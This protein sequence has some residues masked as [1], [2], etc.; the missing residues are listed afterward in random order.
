MDN[1]YEAGSGAGFVGFPEGDREFRKSAG[2]GGSP[3]GIEMDK[4][5]GTGAEDRSESGHGG[6]I[7]VEFVRGRVT[8]VGREDGGVGAEELD[9]GVGS[10]LDSRFV[11]DVALLPGSCTEADWTG[12][13]DHPG[14]GQDA[15]VASTVAFGI[16]SAVVFG[17]ETEYGK[18]DPEDTDDGV[19]SVLLGDVADGRGFIIP[20]GPDGEI[21]YAPALLN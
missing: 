5:N 11:E 14:E 21:E 16:K 7:G 18:D 10:V 6:G 3:A 13:E 12:P 17:A 9:N 1:E 20:S 19:F 2:E 15:S 8:G 4:R